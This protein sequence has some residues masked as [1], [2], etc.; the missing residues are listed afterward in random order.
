MHDNKVPIPPT[1]MK[2]RTDVTLV[3]LIS[4]IWYYFAWPSFCE[5]VIFGHSWYSAWTNFAIG[6]ILQFLQARHIFTHTISLEHI[7]YFLL[8]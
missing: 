6:Y 2:Y 3:Y 4:Q 7:Y 5:I 8:R 1:T